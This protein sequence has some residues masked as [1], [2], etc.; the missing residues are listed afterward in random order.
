MNKIYLTLIFC[1]LTLIA[2]SQNSSVEKSTY[3]IQTGFLG[4]WAHNE[5]KL[6]NK[7]ALRS[8]IGFDTGINGGGYYHNVGFILEPVITLEPRWYYN[9]NKRLEKDRRIDGNSGN[10]I[11][12]KT[13]FHPDWFLISNYDNNL[14]IVSNISIVPTWGIRRNV[15]N[16]FNYET[17]F[18]VGYLYYFAKSAGYSQNSGDLA[19]NLLLRIG[20]RF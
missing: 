14:R 6:S 13:S 7:I 18:G 11:S 4:I 9:L 12:L 16:H 15:G 10:F 17:G 2:K 8:E 20:Y 19:V 3:G 1:G 5:S